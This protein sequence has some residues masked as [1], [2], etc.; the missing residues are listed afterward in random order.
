MFFDRLLIFIKLRINIYNIYYKLY[1]LII[2]VI[3]WLE[4]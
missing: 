2:I 1:V 4:R 3:Y